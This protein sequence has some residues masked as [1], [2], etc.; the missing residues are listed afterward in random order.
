MHLHDNLITDITPLIRLQN[1]EEVRTSL[2]NPVK[3]L[4]HRLSALD[5]DIELDIAVDIS[6]LDPLN[7]VV[8]VPDTNLETA[9]REALSLPED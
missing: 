9:I 6:Q 5:G 4:Y 1:L 3:E 7:L 2:D 8:A